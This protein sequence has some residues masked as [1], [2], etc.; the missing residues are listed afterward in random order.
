MIYK[1]QWLKIIS[2]KKAPFNWIN[3]T[4]AI[5][6]FSLVMFNVYHKG[7]TGYDLAGLL[8][9]T[10]CLVEA[11]RSNTPEWYLRSPNQ[12]FNN[13]YKIDDK[14]IAAS[15]HEEAALWAHLAGK[16]QEPEKIGEVYFFEK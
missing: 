4:L 15:T 9:G 14:Y 10:S 12:T 7:F 3:W 1:N 6:L 13:L 8:V 16:E 11:L 2:F 5:S